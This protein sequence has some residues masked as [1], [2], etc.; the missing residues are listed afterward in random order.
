VA[1]VSEKIKIGDPLLPDVDGREQRLRFRWVFDGQDQSIVPTKGLHTTVI[2]WGFLEAPDTEQDFYQSLVRASFFWPLTRR[3]RLL[4]AGTAGHAFDDEIPLMYQ[5]TLGG[6]LRLSAFEDE[7]FRGRNALLGQVGYL[8]TIGRLPDF[9]GGPIYIIG[10]AEMGSAYE[11]Y[12][13]ADFRFSGT[14]GLLM[15]SALGPFFIGYSVGDDGS[16]RFLFSLGRW[17]R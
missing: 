7:E 3:D 8:R 1:Y 2:G 10:L 9:V 13:Q 6:P 4:F 12:D 17:F 14:G 11:D 16:T 15:E 5:F